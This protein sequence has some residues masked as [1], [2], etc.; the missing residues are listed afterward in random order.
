MSL[1][2][3]DSPDIVQT[4]TTAISEPAGWFLLKYVSRDTVELLGSGASGILEARS[5]MASYEEKSPLYGLIMFRRKRVVI[6]YVPE[7]T[8]RLL[9]ARTTVHF[10][11]V[12]EKYS[13][14]DALLDISS[15]DGLSDTNLAATFPLH[16]GSAG[17][18]ANPLDEITEDAEEP[19]SPPPRPAT[20]SPAPSKMSRKAALDRMA[21]YKR[22]IPIVPKMPQTDNT[23]P[24]TATPEATEAVPAA[25]VERELD[26]SPAPDLHDRPEIVVQELEQVTD[27]TAEQASISTE[28]TLE[29]S[30]LDPTETIGSES[31]SERASS[32]SPYD[33]IHANPDAR[34]DSAVLKD[35]EFFDYRP[36]IKLAPRPVQLLDRKKSSQM[37]L[38]TKRATATLPARVQIRR[39]LADAAA[40]ADLAAPAARTMEEA[41]QEPSVPPND[42]PAKP[43]PLLAALMDAPE[44]PTQ[45]SPQTQSR[46]PS[47]ASFRTGRMLRPKTPLTPEKQRLMKAVEM[48][49]KHLRQSRSASASQSPANSAREIPTSG[50][51][52]ASVAG[53]QKPETEGSEDVF[54]D[55]RASF[56]NQSAKKSD[57]GVE[58]GSE[59]VQDPTAKDNIKEE[60]IEDNKDTE[61]ELPDVTDALQT[62]EDGVVDTLPGE[63]K[64]DPAP[65]SQ[66][67]AEQEKSPAMDP[68]SDKAN[69]DAS[70]DVPSKKL[71]DERAQT[72]DAQPQ[73]PEDDA[74][75]EDPIL[76]ATQAS[77]E[78]S[79]PPAVQTQTTSFL[80]A[81][82]SARDGSLASNDEVGQTA[83]Y[84]DSISTQDDGKIQEGFLDTASEKSGVR[85]TWLSDATE[86]QERS[87]S[88]ESTHRLESTPQR[89]KRRGIVAPI[90]IPLSSSQAVRDGSLDEDDFEYF[91]DATVHE[92]KSLSVVR[93]PATPVV[94]RK[95]SGFSMVSSSP[96]MRPATPSEKP[97]L[98]RTKT[99][100]LVETTS[101]RDLSVDDSRASMR[102]VKSSTA[103]LQPDSAELVSTT[104][105]GQIGSGI[106][107]RI[108]KL[109]ESR[110]PHSSPLPSPKALPT[111]PSSSGGRFAKNLFSDRPA[112]AAASHPDFIKGR[113]RSIGM[114]SGSREPPKAASTPQNESNAYYTVHT[115]PNTRRQSVS[116][117]TKIVRPTTRT[118]NEA[119]AD[120]ETPSVTF[121]SDTENRRPSV[122]PSPPARR[123]RSIAS[124]VSRRSMD[125]AKFKRFSFSR[126]KS[127]DSRLDSTAGSIASGIAPP[128]PPSP[129][130]ADPPSP[131]KRNRTS[132]FFK[133]MSNLSTVSRKRQTKTD[134]APPA[135][136]IP[137]FASPSLPSPYTPDKPLP[138]EP[139]F[140]LADIEPSLS[141][142][143]MDST[144]P[145]PSI[146]I[147]DVNA[148][149]PGSGL[150]K[151]RFVEIDGS[152]M[153]VFSLNDKSSH[154]TRYGGGNVPMSLFNG[155]GRQQMQGTKAWH[156]REVARVF[157]P[158]LDDMELAHSVVLEL[159]GEEGEVVVACEDGRGQGEVLNVLL[160]YH[161][162]WSAAGASS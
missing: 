114:M 146:R 27:Q 136:P 18:S 98:E 76:G 85:N 121:D 135:L 62:T 64:S 157:V 125:S 155:T 92:A 115:D 144:S 30:Q 116:V 2:G 89:Q 131:S 70:T 66:G 156:M 90:T 54:H 48:R 80:E 32:P 17:V 45:L 22:S 96:T 74:S 105:K 152:G 110:S 101:S 20:A 133:R 140:S 49:R 39:V 123:E 137:E 128:R 25:E 126:A 117:T 127:A 87:S 59:A 97:P 10:Q 162:A 79:T 52:T 78:E 24:T 91:D 63:V 124:T 19:S 61:S 86:L 31:I 130:K 132:R 5:C 120:L 94:S 29:T 60:S 47:E 73:D 58:M 34:P 102:R 38:L 15:I 43:Q 161:Q 69:A 14:Y 44:E 71:L 119:P 129:I 111:P 106:S 149:F 26:P 68:E 28:P 4:F 75:L 1:N 77:D 23:A 41:T 42:A 9:Q 109:A 118:Y 104:R 36:K 8:S 100:P 53:D 151:R 13:P 108:A 95:H 84:D 150:W 93:S 40:P 138:S 141:P 112:S 145:L 139:A 50:T 158:H 142:G 56:S 88:P 72:E 35:I 153:L 37:P 81:A 21:A 113:L 46:P 160:K 55:S 143:M 103:T 83:M 16:A 122:P 67:Q 154:S 148:Q 51:P 3:L 12:V 159:E 57:S 99:S 134:M 6:K 11:D 107:Q 33:P 82:D 7:G 65:E 147:G